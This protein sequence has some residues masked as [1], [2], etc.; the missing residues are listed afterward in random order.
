MKELTD[1][2]KKQLRISSM[3]GL[4][5]IVSIVVAI[6]CFVIRASKASQLDELV[7]GTFEYQQNHIALESAISTCNIIAVLFLLISL[8]TIAI[9]I[10]GLY[11]AG[12]FNKEASK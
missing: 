11:K 5:G 7:K 4:A 12:V 10:F 8:A 9:G 6:V 2:Q 1:E 3:F